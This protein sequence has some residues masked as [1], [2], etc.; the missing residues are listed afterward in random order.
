MVDTSVAVAT[1]STTVKRMTNGSASAGSA[2]TKAR[3][4]SASGR[5][6]DPGHVL[7]AVAPPDHDAQSDGQHQAWQ[8]SA[9][10]QRADRHPGD[11]ADGDQHQAGRHGLGLRAGGRQ[12]CHQV[13]GFRA[14]LDHLGEQ[15][16]R[17]GR[18][19]GG[20]GAGNAGDEIHRAHQDIGQAASDVAQQ[21]GQEIHHR[22]RHAG[23][24]DQQS[25]EHEQRHR[26][27]DQVRHALI[28]PADE[29]QHRHVRGQHHVGERADGEGDGD[30]HAGEHGGADQPDEEQ[31]QVQI[32]EAFQ[33]RV[34]H[35]REQ[36]GRRCQPHQRKR[37]ARP[38]MRGTA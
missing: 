23:H 5:A 9:G 3:A 30:R 22:P 14:A 35:R 31:D 26:Q 27:Q 1:P 34:R 24:L 2:T 32:A 11:R 6:A 18:H 7:V 10:E 29:Q 4:T 13:A 28:E 8:Q 33:P 16:R 38:G 12:Q 25:E 37:H 15:R 17:D 36:R 21:R 19:V 20:L